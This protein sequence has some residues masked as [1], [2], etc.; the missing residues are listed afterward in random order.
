MSIYAIILY[1]SVVSYNN[2]SNN[3]ILV[4]YDE[5]IYIKNIKKY[6]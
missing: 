2:V 6:V 5:K 3:N 4:D 1:K